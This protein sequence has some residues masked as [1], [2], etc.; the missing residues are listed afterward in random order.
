MKS[1]RQYDGRGDLLHG[2]RRHF[3]QIYYS[4]LP[5]KT[6]STLRK[7]Q[8]LYEQ[9]SFICNKEVQKVLDI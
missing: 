6:V 1:Y 8:S 3:R 9:I 5:V 2:A 4:L 7:T